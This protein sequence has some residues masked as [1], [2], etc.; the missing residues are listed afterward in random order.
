MPTLKLTQARVNALEPRPLVDGKRPPVEWL[1]DTHTKG[2]G[3]KLMPSGHKSWVYRYFGGSEDKANTQ[4]VGIGPAGEGGISLDEA[5]KE[6]VRLAAQVVA[7]RGGKDVLP[8]EARREEKAR[9]TQEK[10]RRSAAA[11]ADAAKETVAVAYARWLGSLAPRVKASSLRDW[12]GQLSRHIAPHF[13]GKKVADV[14]EKDVLRLHAKMSAHPAT[15]NRVR[16]RLQTF[17]DWCEKE[18]LRDRH[19]NPAEDVKP[20]REQAKQRFL[21]PDETVAVLAALARAESEGLPAAPETQAKKSGKNKTPRPSRA[22]P[23]ARAYRST[24]RKRAKRGAYT[25]HKEP[26]PIAPANPHAVAALRLLLLTGWRRNEVLSLRWDAVDES[27]SVVVL[28]ET[29]TGKSE[30]P[31]G[32]AALAVIKAQRRLADNPFVFPSP[33]L[34][35]QH[36][37]EVTRLWYAVRHEAGIGHGPDAGLEAVR[38]HDLRHNLASVMVSSGASLPEIGAALGH[39]DAKSTQRYA[40]MMSAPVTARLD[41]AA[42]AILN[43]KAQLKLVS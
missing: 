37:K 18:G 11:L 43:P 41:T 34:K 26:A 15:A 29:K 31:I 19:T 39:R 12:R 32:A 24:D 3:M 38:L 25:R 30:R 6:A 16:S 7:A 23:G 8:H 9:R 40:H 20:Y 4:R 22:K 28:R 42:D 1:W 27:R 10:L 21:S 17:F 33:R 36:L 14:M 13:D 2:L 35:G 5:R